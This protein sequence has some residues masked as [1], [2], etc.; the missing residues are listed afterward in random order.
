M[1]AAC[2][3]LMSVEKQ[4]KTQKN[5]GSLWFEFPDG[6]CMWLLQLLNSIFLFFF[7]CLILL[8]PHSGINDVYLKK[9]LAAKLQQ[10]QEG[11]GIGEREELEKN[12]EPSS[13]TDSAAK[14]AACFAG[15]WQGKAFKGG[16]TCTKQSRFF[17]NSF[18]PCLGA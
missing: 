7:K 15:C 4:N 17:L 11:W 1:A 16:G 14:T 6:L 13:S 18:F 2:S 5:K 8:V 3:D 9:G 10:I 12:S